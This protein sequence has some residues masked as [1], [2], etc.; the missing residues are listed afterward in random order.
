M[1][2]SKLIQHLQKLPQDVPAAACAATFEGLDL[3][4]DIRAVEHDTKDNVVY[5]VL[6]PA[7]R[8]SDLVKSELLIPVSTAGEYIKIVRAGRGGSYQV[9]ISGYKAG[10]RDPYSRTIDTVAGL[11][12]SLALD[13]IDITEARFVQTVATQ[14]SEAAD[15]YT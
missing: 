9:K 15:H 5:L 11:C 3:V 8:L 6:A 10:G 12:L 14:L 4:A 1:K 13:G 2:V 7:V